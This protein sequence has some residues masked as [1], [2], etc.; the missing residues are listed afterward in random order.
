[1]IYVFL[2]NG[3]EEIEAIAPIDMLRRA[4]VEVQTVG[5]GTDHPTGSH[6]ITVRAD[7]PESAV[8]TDGLQGVILPGGLP[9]TTNLEA[10]ATVQRLLEHCAANDLLIAAICAAPSVLGHKGLLDGRRYTCYPGF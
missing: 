4:G 6:G 2:A 7:L 5:I 3:F 10:S 1:M 8:T 9:G